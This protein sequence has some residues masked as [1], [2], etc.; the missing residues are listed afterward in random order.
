MTAEEFWNN[1]PQLTPPV[2]PPPT[3]GELLR[4]ALRNKIEELFDL[5][6]DYWSSP[7]GGYLLKLELSSFTGFSSLKWSSGI[8]FNTEA[9]SL[10]IFNT[11]LIP[12]LSEK[13]SL[14]DNVDFALKEMLKCKE[15]S[16]L[17]EVFEELNSQLVTTYEARTLLLDSKLHHIEN[18]YKH[19]SL[20][21]NLIL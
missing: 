10:S 6:K 14:S 4:E 1:L 20:I 19:M 16:L 18:K 12:L 3:Y 7:G 21:R 13:V 11:T 9:L 15:L 8:Y 17:R 2:I 5:Y